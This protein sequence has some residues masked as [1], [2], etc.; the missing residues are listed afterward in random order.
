MKSHRVLSLT[1]ETGHLRTDHLWPKCEREDKTEALC[2]IHGTLYS[3]WTPSQFMALTF[4]LHYL[5]A[6]AEVGKCHRVSI[7]DLHPDDLNS[8]VASRNTV[9][10]NY[11]AMMTDVSIRL[12]LN[13]ELIIRRL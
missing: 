12:S 10:A 9:I 2:T 11:A 8:K 5:I 3:I 6:Q 13:M 4:G 7:P 1:L